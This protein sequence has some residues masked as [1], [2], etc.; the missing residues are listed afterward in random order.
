MTQN[1]KNEMVLFGIIL[2]LWVVGIGIGLLFV[3]F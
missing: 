2:L 3:N 1:K